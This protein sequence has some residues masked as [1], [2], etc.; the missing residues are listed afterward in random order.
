MYVLVEKGIFTVVQNEGLCLKI[1]VDPN[2][3]LHINIQKV[4]PVLKTVLLLSDLPRL[5]SSATAQG[6][7]TDRNGFSF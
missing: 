2:I 1:S 5:Y 6:L 3:V 4:I 7:Q